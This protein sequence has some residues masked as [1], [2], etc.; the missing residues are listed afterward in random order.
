MLPGASHTA[1]FPQYNPPI[2][3]DTYIQASVSMETQI[4]LAIVMPVFEWVISAS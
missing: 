4:T 1:P 2:N 3:M